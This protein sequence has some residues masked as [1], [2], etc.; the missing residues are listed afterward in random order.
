MLSA[1]TDVG[2]KKGP[3]MVVPPAMVSMGE[4]RQGFDEVAAILH[5]APFNSKALALSFYL[6]RSYSNK[7]LIAF[8]TSA[9]ANITLTL[10][11]EPWRI[12]DP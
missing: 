4:R 1:F 6:D 8:A 5:T 3:D 11:L 12:F 10:T 2:P 7:I 9:M